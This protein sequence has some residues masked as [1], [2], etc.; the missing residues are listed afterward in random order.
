[1]FFDFDEKERV[2][3]RTLTYTDRREIFRTS[4]AGNIFKQTVSAVG[5]FSNNNVKEE[6][7][8]GGLSFSCKSA[9]SNY[10]KIVNPSLQKDS[11][12]FQLLT[13]TCMFLLF[14]QNKSWLPDWTILGPN[15]RN[16]DLF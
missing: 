11:Q 16:L 9:V 7:V 2:R 14:G 1:M 6:Q 8:C 5:N 4:R 12:V 3:V 10:K 15:S 13:L